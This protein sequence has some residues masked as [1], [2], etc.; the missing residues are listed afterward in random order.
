M[1]WSLVFLVMVPVGSTGAQT[2]DI[3]V[4]VGASIRSLPDIVPVHGLYPRLPRPTEAR[5]VV[6]TRLEAAGLWRRSRT[7][8]RTPPSKP[9]VGDTW[10]WYIW[11]LGGYP[12]ATLKPCTV[13]GMGNNCYIVE[14][15]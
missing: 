2:E 9:E 10:D 8:G 15:L 13:R 12:T 5:D 11:D 14:F 1:L 6:K 7:K 4:E 3:Q